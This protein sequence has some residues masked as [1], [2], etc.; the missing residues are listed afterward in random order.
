[1]GVKGVTVEN[2]LLWIARNPE[3][4]MEVTKAYKAPDI[5]ILQS[6]ELRINNQDS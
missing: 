3:W 1:M 4:Q 6:R 5:D 2:Y